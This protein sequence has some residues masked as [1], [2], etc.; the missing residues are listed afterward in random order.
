MNNMIDIAYESF[1]KEFI[2]AY[3]KES[4]RKNQLKAEHAA[5]VE[6]CEKVSRNKSEISKI[7]KA[8]RPELVSKYKDPIYIIYGTDKPA[9]FN[10]KSL[11]ENDLILEVEEVDTDSSYGRD[12]IPTIIMQY[13]LSMSYLKYLMK[14]MLIRTD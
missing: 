4:T 9:K 11:T 10:G 6:L 2:E 5:R 12:N 13:S 1:V 14:W 7:D 3:K 8:I